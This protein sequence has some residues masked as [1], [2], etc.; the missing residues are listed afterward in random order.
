M[1]KPTSGVELELYVLRKIN[2]WLNELMSPAARARVLDWAQTIQ[3]ESVS[4][5]WKDYNLP[6]D[7]DLPEAK[8]A[9]R[10]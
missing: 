1:A 4:T 9:P 2:I 10:A 6:E 5:D 3:K 7:S 8:E